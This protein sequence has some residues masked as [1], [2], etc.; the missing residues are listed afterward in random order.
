[1][2]VKLDVRVNG[3]LC[4]IEYLSVCVHVQA[5][6]CISVRVCACVCESSKPSFK[7]DNVLSFGIKVDES[8][9]K[10]PVKHR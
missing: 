3:G 8:D 7:C 1:M 2:F 6:V 5:W 4:Y 10:T 9:I